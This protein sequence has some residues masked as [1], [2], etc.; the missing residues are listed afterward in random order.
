[1]STLTLS[2]AD[3]QKT[4]PIRQAQ[5]FLNFACAGK[6][7]KSNSKQCDFNMYRLFPVV[8][9]LFSA[10]FALAED[11]NETLV[12]SYAPYL[13]GKPWPRWPVI[14]YVETTSNIWVHPTDPKHFPTMQEICEPDSDFDTVILRLPDGTIYKTYDDPVMGPGLEAV[15]MGDFNSDGKPDFMALK[16]GG[17][18]GLAG[19]YCTGIFAFSDQGS[20]WLTRVRT[21]DLSPEDLVIEPATKQFRLVHTSFRSALAI[22]GQYHSFWVHRFFIWNGT[23]FREDPAITPIW[24][25]YLYRSN[26]EPTKLL[27]PDLKQKA[28]DEDSDFND[29]EW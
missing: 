2:D 15:Y 27:T 5:G 16:G 6:I 26:H 4:K 8:L 1:M 14:A 18:C 12:S 25:Q 21:M 7:K 19:E 3:D 23:G 10:A 13:N 24:I 20:Y 11:T 9:L 29:I 28:W 17:G 22:D